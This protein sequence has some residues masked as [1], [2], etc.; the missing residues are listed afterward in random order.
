MDHVS[1]EERAKWERARLIPVSGIGNAQEAERRAASA[2]LV[3]TDLAE[4]NALSAELA[5][6]LAAGG[7]G[8]LTGR[9]TPLPSGSHRN[10][11]VRWSVRPRSLRR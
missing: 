11:P 7:Q 5:D 4:A 8:E 3:E 9:T 2:L 10:A 1:D 6:E